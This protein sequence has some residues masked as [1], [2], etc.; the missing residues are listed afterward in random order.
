MTASVEKRQRARDE[1]TVLVLLIA[2]SCPVSRVRDCLCGCVW[3]C[4]YLAVFACLLV[5]LLHFLKRYF[6]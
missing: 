4:V 1:M 3:V 5:L 2:S 6:S